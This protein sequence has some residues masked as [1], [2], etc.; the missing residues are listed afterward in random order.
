MHHKRGPQNRE[1]KQMS[2]A[3]LWGIIREAFG[4]VVAVPG[5]CR[6]PK[7]TKE[8]EE[9]SACT[10]G[11]ATC[12]T[13]DSASEPNGTR[14]SGRP[15]GA[16]RRWAI[17]DHL[18]AACAMFEFKF[19]SLLQFSSPLEHVICRNLKRL[20]GMRSV[21][22]DTHMREELDKVN[23]EELE[24]A[25]REVFHAAQRN[26]VLEHRVFYEGTYL[27]AIDGTEMFRSQ[28]VHCPQCCKK[29]H[30]DGTITYHHNLMAASIVCPGIRTVLPMFPEPILKQD[31]ASKNDCEQAAARRLLHRIRRMHPHLR[32]T[33]TADAMQATGPQIRFIQSLGYDYLLKIQ[34][35]S[36]K[37][38]LNEV[39]NLFDLDAKVKKEAA[40]QNLHR[41][42]RQLSKDGANSS[43]SGKD[44]ALNESDD[45]LIGSFSYRED[46]S[47]WKVRWVNQVPLSGAPDAPTVNYLE[48][49]K[50]IDLEDPVAARKAQ[51]TQRR[52]QQAMEAWKAGKAA[53]GEPD[54]EPILEEKKKKTAT[55]AVTSWRITKEN[56]KRILDGVK[57]E[58]KIENETFNTLKNQGY[59]F[60]H[61]FGHGYLNLQAVLATLMML[62]FLVDQIV[63]ATCGLYAQA[64]SKIRGFKTLWE[65]ART[66]LQHFEIPSWRALW[67]YISGDDKYGLPEYQD[68]S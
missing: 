24:G 31:G 63:A 39:N 11:G 48:V 40:E 41:S 15:R 22:S 5:R 67:A 36:H 4:T 64:R 51:N 17:T 14:A 62:T 54:A 18:M 35:G 1:K 56:A 59:Q 20:F 8:E 19:P 16:P 29:L 21:P 10:E 2:N 55:S 34:P 57:A 9:T 38:L 52:E 6:K 25:Y 28:K 23:P 44:G 12:C 50:S 60:E 65:H 7:E 33:I 3:G 32:L 26:G 42:K 61:N 27:L 13:D 66:L 46:G 45:A 37:T 47:L 49:Q 30:R 68:S 53:A 43:C 58:W